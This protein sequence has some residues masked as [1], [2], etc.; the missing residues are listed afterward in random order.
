M[1][2]AT[3]EMAVGCR[4]GARGTMRSDLWPRNLVSKFAIRSQISQLASPANLV[5]RG[6][7][8]SGQRRIPNQRFLGCADSHSRHLGSRSSS[9]APGQAHDRP[10]GGAL[11][12]LRVNGPALPRNVLENSHGSGWA[13][14]VGHTQELGQ[15]GTRRSGV[16][17]A[18]M[19]QPLSIVHVLKVPPAI[20]GS[21]APGLHY[22]DT[23]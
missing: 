6:S 16:A 14:L 13:V 23:S 8:D 15:C 21:G 4:S 7:C 20:V 5:F 22:R 18:G 3:L 19:W 9:L 2:L 17:V 11:S 1:H 10:P 12:W